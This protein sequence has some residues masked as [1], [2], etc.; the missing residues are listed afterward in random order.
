MQMRAPPP[1][2]NAHVA[3][4]PAGS[5]RPAAGPMTGIAGAAMAGISIIGAGPI[6]RSSSGAITPLRDASAAARSWPAAA[7]RANAILPRPSAGGR[8]CAWL[9]CVMIRTAPSIGISC[10]TALR[11]ARRWRGIDPAPAVHVP[12]P[13]PAA[14][15]A[16]VVCRRPH[17]IAGGRV[18]MRPVR[19]RWP[20]GAGGRRRPAR[21]VGLPMLRFGRVGCRRA[22]PARG[23]V[24]LPP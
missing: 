18:D 15:A 5:N 24:R 6:S 22:A 1:L 17:Q 9:Y 20:G 14:P 21:A 16:P 13:A 8:R 23:A 2:P 4:P 12:P 3:G 11:A 19:P 7:R 10:R